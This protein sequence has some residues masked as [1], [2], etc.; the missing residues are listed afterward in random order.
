MTK[1][2]TLPSKTAWS[3]SGDRLVKKQT[4]RCDKCCG[5]YLHGCTSVTPNPGQGVGWKGLRERNWGRSPESVNTWETRSKPKQQPSEHVEWQKISPE[6]KK[7][8]IQ[9]YL[10]RHAKESALH[11]K[12][13]RSHCTSFIWEMISDLHFKNHHSVQNVAAQ[14]EQN[15]R[16]KDH[17]LVS[18]LL[19]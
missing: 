14:T 15:W 8:Q 19:Q 11:P 17:Q 5:G 10:I 3:R 4:I 7:V 13:L 18:K 12:G 9:K 1:S 2:L 16:Q 6:V